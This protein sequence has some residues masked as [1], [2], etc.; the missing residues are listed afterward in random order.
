MYIYA[1]VDLNNNVFYVGQ[2]KDPYVR[3]LNHV[4]KSYLL[5]TEKD[6]ILTEMCKSGIFPKF[7][8]L[9]EIV[10]DLNDKK[11]I[12][13]VSDREFYWINQFSHL[14]NLQKRKIKLKFEEI[15]EN[16]PKCEYCNE[17]MQKGTAKKRFCSD[18]C[19]VY[20]NR[21]S[22]SVPVI[23]QTAKISIQ[24][25]KMINTI[26]ITEKPH[27][28]PVIQ[29]IEKKSSYDPFSNPRFKSKL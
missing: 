25:E 26:K 14:S 20:F 1:L 3:L 22:K 29:K 11:S 13:N 8:I 12:F 21:E 2:S 5:K 6:R 7:K 17:K 9:E 27:F 10:V 16:S 23:A 4:S 19:R 18:K 15:P 28:E 24:T